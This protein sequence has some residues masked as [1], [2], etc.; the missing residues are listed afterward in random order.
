MDTTE[1]RES[2]VLTDTKYSVRHNEN[3]QE[4]NIWKATK[5]LNS[6][7]K[8]EEVCGGITDKSQAELICTLLNNHIDSISQTLKLNKMTKAQLITKQQLEIEDLRKK[9]AEHKKIKSA[10]HN[11][12]YAMG[13]PLNDN[14]LAFNHK[15]MQWCAGVTILIDQL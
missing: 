13:A 4:Y 11:K 3:L 14:I 2:I 6:G 12:F 8:G 9:I 10:L 15:Q 1:K 5:S 7:F